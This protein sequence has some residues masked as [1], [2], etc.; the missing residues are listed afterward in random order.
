[1]NGHRAAAP[2]RAGKQ[3]VTIFCDRTGLE[4]FASAGRTYVPFP[5]TP[6]GENRSL[7]VNVSGAPARFT[8]LVVHELRSAWVVQGETP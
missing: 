1:V 8:S 4:V 3:Q 2:L 5:F 6:Q 7:A